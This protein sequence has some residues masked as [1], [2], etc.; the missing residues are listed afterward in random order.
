MPADS[1]GTADTADSLLTFLEDE[2]RYVRF[3]M[4]ISLSD[5]SCDVCSSAPIFI[6]A[7]YRCFVEMFE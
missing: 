7:T 6:Q 5:E 4:K 3:F 1:A 2:G